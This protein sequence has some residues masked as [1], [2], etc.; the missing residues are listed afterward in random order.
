[1]EAHCAG[2]RLA[3]SPRWLRV[4]PCFATASPTQSKSCDQLLGSFQRSCAV[5]FFLTGLVRPRARFSAFRRAVKFLDFKRIKLNYSAPMKTSFLL[6]LCLM[7][8]SYTHLRAHE[9]DSY[10]VCR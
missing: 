7:S 6:L 3:I 2:F 10:L 4:D 8:V 1:M 9:T 5:M